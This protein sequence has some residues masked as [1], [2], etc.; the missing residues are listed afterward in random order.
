MEKGVNWKTNFLGKKGLDEVKSISKENKDKT[1]ILSD[2]N[3]S[4]IGWYYLK[5]GRFAKRT[6]ENPNYDFE[7]NKTIL[8]AKA[9]VVYKFREF[10][11]KF[12]EG[13]KLKKF[14]GKAKKVGGKAYEKGRKVAHYTKEA[15]KES[16][17]N[18]SKR[19]TMGVLSVVKADRDVS[20]KEV[21]HI[22]KTED[23]VQEH[24]Q[25]E[26][27][28]FV[29]KKEK[30][31]ST[32]AKGGEISH[33]RQRVAEFLVEMDWDNGK[34]HDEL[35]ND[36]TVEKAI[37]WE[38]NN[39]IKTDKDAQVYLDKDGDLVMYANGGEITVENEDERTTLSLNGIG[40]IVITETTPEYEFVDDI[41]EDELENLDL[42]E[43]D[44][45]SKIEDLRIND[46]HKG[47]G[48]AKLLMNKALDY[49]DENYSYP[50]YL[51]ASPMQS[52]GMLNL[53]DLT[54]F[55]EKFGF[56]VFKRQGGNNLMIKKSKGNTYAEGGMIHKTQINEDGSNMPE[57]LSDVFMDF[58]ENEDSYEEM[59]RLRLKANE[60]GYDFDY[61]LSGQPTEFWEIEKNKMKEGGEVVKRGYFN[62]FLSFLNY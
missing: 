25:F 19:N 35:G 14:F 50:I 34:Y 6:T 11:T 42:Y 40:S 36:V 32:Y 52:D 59:E 5:N 53:N 21:D 56:K 1:Y 3:N 22:E 48:Y 7:N 44:F 23:L 58:D 47:K 57:P 62:G 43:D 15:A 31:V 39:N 37:Q 54:G 60:V 16:M 13:G 49:I 46:G 26:P 33:S 55:Y 12:A 18:S 9:G 41:S 29:P 27:T 2:D 8:R 28:P 30:G 24:Y 61:D 45:I 17:H 51:N 10:P 20:N 4:N 38:L